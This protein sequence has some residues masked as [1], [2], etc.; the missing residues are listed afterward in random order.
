MKH[1]HNLKFKLFVVNFIV[2]S[3]LVFAQKET[4]TYKESYKVNNDVVI[5]INT[6]YADIEFET[7]NRN[8]VEVEAVL[9]VEGLSKEEAEEY[10]KEWN[11]HVTGNSSKVS[12]SAKTNNRI[13][14]GDDFTY[15]ST[16]GHEFDFD[17]DF[18]I[19]EP[20][21]VEIAPF[22]VEM[23]H[24]PSVPPLPPLPLNFD[25]FSFDYEAYKKDGDKYLEEW[26]EEFNKHFNEDFRENLEEWK[27][28]VDEQRKAVEGRK[29]EIEKYREE[30]QQKRQEIREKQHEIR[31]KQRVVLQEARERAKEARNEAMSK[32]REERTK[33][34]VFFLSTGK[35]KNLKVKKTIKIKM[36]KKAKLKMNVRHGEVKLA[37]NFKS[38]NAT[39]SHTRLLATVVDGENSVI[40]A[41]YSPVKV[42]NWNYGELKVNYVK[43]VNLQNV[44]SV[45]LLSKSSDVIIGKISEDAIIDCSFGNLNVDNIGAD[46]KQFEVTLD[47]SDAIIVLPQNGAFD[48]YCSSSDSKVEYPERLNLAISKKYSNEQAKGYNQNKNSSKNVSIVATFSD[49]KIK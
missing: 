43:N 36:P 16:D 44:K 28:Q 14:R 31:E 15:I 25:S 26:K 12:I 10:F 46:F 17:F 4:K 42:E 35:N 40:E 45:K 23:P 11:L 39:L 32:M 18:D 20:P 49:V 21:T 7:W 41:S 3:A 19:P 22:V 38:I 37:D 9:E 6:S 34:N 47:N 27:K 24:V 30:M 5:D 13:V 48:F 8:T 1:I 2:F 29:K 33:P